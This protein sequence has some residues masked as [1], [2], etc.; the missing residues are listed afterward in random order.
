M[1]IKTVLFDIPQSIESPIRHVEDFLERNRHRLQALRLPDYKTEKFV[2][3]F[4]NF[5]DTEQGNP[6]RAL[7]VIYLAWYDSPIIDRALPERK[8]EAAKLVG[9]D[10][11]KNRSI[12]QLE[13]K[14]TWTYF[15]RFLAVQ[16]NVAHDFFTRQSHIYGLM[17][18]RIRIALKDEESLDKKEIANWVK[19][20]FELSTK[21]MEYQR[22]MYDA[23]TTRLNERRQVVDTRG[24]T[25]DFAGNAEDVVVYKAATLNLYE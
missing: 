20:I 8:E 6:A 14:A 10:L 2:P 11:E 1:N 22:A 24:E 19:T 23:T 4:E 3:V 16:H 12:I 18:E 9:Y 17:T 5:A 15:D 25:P 7:Y 21:A 13:D